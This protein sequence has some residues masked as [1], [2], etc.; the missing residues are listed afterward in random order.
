MVHRHETTLLLTPLK[1]REIDHPETLKVH[2]VHQTLTTSH[3]ETESSQLSPA[4]HRVVTAKDQDQIARLSLH[5]I[6]QSGSLLLGVELVDTALDTAVLI[7]AGIDQSLG[8]HMRA[9]HVVGQLIELLAGISG[10]ALGTDTA[11]VGGLIK[12]SESGLGERLLQLHD[13]HIEAH[14][15]LIR[16]VVL[17]RILPVHLEVRLSL[18]YAEDLLE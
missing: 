2:R 6:A 11:D 1:E 15:R 14:I 7:D 17:H 8:T 18:L 16:A 3:L 12:D 10:A 9:L 4:L 13:P 5:R